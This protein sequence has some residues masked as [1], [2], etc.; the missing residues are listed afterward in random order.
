MAVLS[1]F[2]T[3]SPTALCGLLAEEARLRVFAAVVL[4]ARSPSTVEEA[5]G[6]SSRTVE[7]AIRRLQQGGLL[8][9]ADGT[10][11]PLVAAFKDSVRSEAAQA[12]PA[13]RLDPDRQ[14]DQVLRTFIVDGR[15]ARMPAAHGK[16]LVVLE[17]I[18]A[19]FEP[20]VR[21]PEREVD[22]VL[23]AWFDDYAALRRYLVDTGL[24]SR[25]DNVYWRSGGAVDV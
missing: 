17:H 20:G 21:Y 12:P 16:R 24:L 23:R 13:E 5:S 25:A 6:L 8:D 11:V 7:G 1:P 4:G 15:L 2:V 3:P 10:L 22:A 18:A 14:R 19:S 9:V